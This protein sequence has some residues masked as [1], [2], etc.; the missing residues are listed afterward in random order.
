MLQRSRAACR[1]VVKGWAARGCN[2]LQSDAVCSALST[3]E[4]SAELIGSHF[5][6]VFRRLSIAAQPLGHV[7]GRPAPVQGTPWGTLAAV[8]AHSLHRYVLPIIEDQAGRKE[9]HVPSVGALDTCLGRA[10]S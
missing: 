1:L 7:S 4:A 6:L 10:F 8:G 3:A 9:V 5:P 2:Q